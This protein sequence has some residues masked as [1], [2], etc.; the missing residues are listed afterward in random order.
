MRMTQLGTVIVLP[1]FT[2]TID[3]IQQNCCTSM[4]HI[5]FDSIQHANQSGTK[6][7]YKLPLESFP[8]HALFRE[9]LHDNLP[10]END[11]KISLCPI[12]SNPL[13]IKCIFNVRRFEMLFCD[14]NF[15]SLLFV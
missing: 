8:L 10:K 14:I 15:K 3:S 5:Q 2:Y 4:V 1:W 12:T 7:Y 6:Q 9:L 13:K 11:V